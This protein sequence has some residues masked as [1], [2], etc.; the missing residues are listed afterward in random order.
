M[1]SITPLTV[2]LA[3]GAGASS[4]SPPPMLATLGPPV[5]YPVVEARRQSHLSPPVEQA[6]SLPQIGD[7]EWNSP[8]ALALV[9]LGRET[10]SADGAGM[11]DL[12][13]YMT[14]AMGRVH[15]FFD[16]ADSGERTLIRGDQLALDVH[17]SPPNILRQNI[18]GWR[19]KEAFPSNI[20]YHLDHLIVLHD[21]FADRMRLGDGDEVA[22]VLH[23]LA[24]GSEAIYDFSLGDSLTVTQGATDEVTNVR[25]VLVRPRSVDEPGF[26]GSIYLDVSSGSVVRMSYTF[27]PASYVDP[28]LEYVRIHL[29]NGLWGGRRWLPYRQTVE[30]RRELPSFDFLGG[31]TIRTTF[32]VGPYEFGKPLP[33]WLITAP[34]VTALPEAVRSAFP[35][36][37][38]VFAEAAAGGLDEPL[39]MKQVRSVASGIIAQER[40]SALDPVRAHVPRLSDLVRYNRAE[41]LF[42]GGGLSVRPMPALTA[43]VLSGYSFGRSAPSGS[44][45]MTFGASDIESAL[46]LSWD[47]SR[48][49][50]QA[51]GSDPSLNSLTVALGGTDRFDPMLVRG[52]S[53]RV[54]GASTSVVNGRVRV[55]RHRSATDVLSDRPGEDRRVVLPVQEGTMV[56]ADMRVALRGSHGLG[57]TVDASVGRMSDEVF[58]S[59]IAA[60]EWRTG[61]EGGGRRAR[62]GLS[63]GG[64]TSATPPQ[65]LYLLGGRG[66]LP[67]HA[68]RAFVGDR[69]WLLDA[70][71]VLP[72]RAPFLALRTFFHAGASYLDGS[73]AL[74]EAWPTT[75]TDGTMASVGAGL[76]LGWE[77]VSVDLAKG[78]KGGGWELYISLRPQLRSWS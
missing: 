72:L 5:A 14:R 45:E 6:A 20:H 73:R 53:L 9:T 19:Q 36:P 17:W 21:D 8:S 47:A 25:E 57:V 4:G 32:E 52:V 76:A 22:D 50:G 1:I 24:Q 30:L 18:V 33:E 44:L 26:V 64:A 69:Y 27:T 58:G 49:L 59:L 3:V 66:T 28:A 68:Y 34:I 39:P 43:R 35:F 16:R 37:D 38:P 10:R 46:L 31:T 40:L 77:T 70:E 60:A 67:G 13:S 29:E 75:G 7:R 62:I 63:G 61:V 71:A 12:P 48:D 41:G 74:P 23:P 15:F 54:A 42:L 2:A 56:V 55:E 78:L 51:S 65:G 11:E